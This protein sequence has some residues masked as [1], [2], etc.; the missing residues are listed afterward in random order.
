MNPNLV[1]DLT[2]ALARNGTW[3]A[4]IRKT[5]DGEQYV[6]LADDVQSQPVESVWFDP[7]R[8]VWG[9]E[10]QFSV[11]ADDDTNDIANAI[12]YTLRDAD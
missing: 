8:V 12:L 3:T 9:S 11:P 10:Y 5:E 4:I 1:E 6:D 2:T 7:T